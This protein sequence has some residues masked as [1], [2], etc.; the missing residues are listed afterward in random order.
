MTPCFPK[1]FNAEAETVSSVV[2][3]PCVIK[4][5]PNRRLIKMSARKKNKEGHS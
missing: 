3:T 2:I 1:F 4:V 5:K